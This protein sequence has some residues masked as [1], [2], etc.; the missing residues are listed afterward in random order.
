VQTFTII[1]G[2][3]NELRAPIHNRMPVILPPAAWRMWLGEEEADADELL[4][5]LRPLPAELM[6]A[7]PVDVRVGSLHNND[8]ELLTESIA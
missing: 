7:Y 4:G 8:R 5:L 6:R 2:P 3:P 1:T